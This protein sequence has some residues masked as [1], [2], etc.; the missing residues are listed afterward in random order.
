MF[1]FNFDCTDA[2]YLQILY[3]TQLVYL[4]TTVCLVLGVDILYGIF[5]SQLLTQFK[6][7]NKKFEQI[8][9]IKTNKDFIKNLEDGISYH[10]KLIEYYY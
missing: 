2:F 4:L 8:G 7:L 10:V 1:L 9:N 5:C 6:L 3:I